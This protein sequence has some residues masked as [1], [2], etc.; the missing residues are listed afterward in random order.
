MKRTLGQGRYP[1][2]EVL[3][4]SSRVKFRTGGRGVDLSRSGARILLSAYTCSSLGPMAWEEIVGK[5][6]VNVA[7]RNEPR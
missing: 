6:L 5:L 2:P 7:R 4:R 1:D 3:A